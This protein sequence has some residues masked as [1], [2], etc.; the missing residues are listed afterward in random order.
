[1]SYNHRNPTYQ[2]CT[3]S[4][5]FLFCK[6]HWRDDEANLTNSKYTG[7]GGDFTYKGSEY[8][9]DGSTSSFASCRKMGWNAVLACKSW[10]GRYGFEQSDGCADRYR[11]YFTECIQEVFGDSCLIPCLAYSETCSFLPAQSQNTTKYC[12]ITAHG[13]ATMGYFQ[14]LSGSG[15]TAFTTNIDVTVSVGKNSGLVSG[16][17]SYSNTSG[18]QYTGS[19][20]GTAFTT[21]TTALR[22]AIRELCELTCVAWYD[23]NIPEWV[24]DYV[25]QHSCGVDC[26]CTDKC[27]SGSGCPE[28]WMPGDPSVWE[29][30]SSYINDFNWPRLAGWTSPSLIANNCAPLTYGVFGSAVLTHTDTTLAY[31]MQGLS[32]AIFG[33]NNSWVN[34][35]ITVELSDPFT[36]DDI[37]ASCE[38]LLARFPLDNTRNWRT[39]TEFWKCPTV[40][41]SELEYPIDPSGY[42]DATMQYGYYTSSNP[43]G[44]TGEL[45]G[46]P[47]PMTCSLAG[48]GSS[49]YDTFYNPL[50]P[51]YVWVG[52]YGG[53]FEW[54]SNGAMCNCGEGATECPPDQLTK[55]DDA[56]PPSHRGIFGSAGGFRFYNN[57]ASIYAGPSQ[58]YI[59]EQLFV[60]K[61][62]ELFIFSR[63][64]VN[65]NR[66]MNGS[67][68][69]DALTRDSASQDCS[70]PGGPSGD[71]YMDI[72]YVYGPTGS[73]YTLGQV[74]EPV[75]PFNLPAGNEKWS[76]YNES[77]ESYWNN[78]GKKY[79]FVDVTWG[80][81]HR[82]YKEIERVN[83]AL[84]ATFAACRNATGLSPQPVIR[85]ITRTL[86]TVQANQNYVYF[87]PCKAIVFS[88][89]PSQSR[90][91]WVRHS[92]SFIDLPRII[93]DAGYGA[94]VRVNGVQWMTDPFWWE[95]IP[96]CD[97]TGSDGTPLDKSICGAYPSSKYSWEEDRGAVQ[98]IDPYTET[99]AALCRDDYVQ[100]D[101][102]A[103]CAQYH[104]YYPM[105][106]LVEART[107]PPSDPCNIHPSQSL[108]A[109]MRVLGC[110]NYI[111]DQNAET[112]LQ[113]AYTHPWK[114]CEFC[115]QPPNAYSYDTLNGFAFPY[116][117]YPWS[118]QAKQEAC[119]SGR[120]SGIYAANGGNEGVIILVP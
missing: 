101:A 28:G 96:F 85:P 31:S 120:Y 109:G 29:C 58:A 30:T 18:S 63:P 17:A 114:Y 99:D 57:G 4:S 11:N 62:A 3:T 22:N 1:M 66:P 97:A 100:E 67:G 78:A 73:A 15:E 34:G 70:Q 74:N 86:K 75:G 13:A 102:Y 36:S 116:I 6:N 38:A 92:A 27:P 21:I 84:A 43:T 115:E 82:D 12:T 5:G 77:S 68:Y 65:W 33:V 107:G 106:P 44:V 20:A 16:T 79:D 61:Y 49:Y 88:V 111:T 2:G 59:G 40:R 112:S 72:Q 119:S 89:E 23:P 76:S 54:N 19:D 64:S 108:V 56:M 9:T 60:R 14:N 41:Y 104:R 35:H 42:V 117:L 118:I 71:Y 52:G 51:N 47:L 24:G 50:H 48:S 8:Y 53:F 69:N 83:S 37:N 45:M 10:H 93:T 25:G 91:T 39:D 103:N 46:D 94:L 55:D 32:S 95:Y 90:T 81:D 87:T 80:Y 98:A 110:D 113:I 105:R 7:G 26:S